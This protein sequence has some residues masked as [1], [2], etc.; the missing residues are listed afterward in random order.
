MKT[1]PK[2]TTFTKPNGEI[3]QFRSYDDFDQWFIQNYSK[4]SSYRTVR[5]NQNIWVYTD[6]NGNLIGELKENNQ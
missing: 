4:F 6:N 2:S 1:I 5:N 3:M